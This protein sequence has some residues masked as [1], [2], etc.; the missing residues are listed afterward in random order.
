MTAYTLRTTRAYF[1]LWYGVM[2]AYRVEILL[3]AIA[4]ALPLIMMGIWVEAGASGKFAGF[5][6][7]DA[8]RYFIAVFVVRQFSVVWV[9]Y[10][11][12]HLV[13]SGKLSSLLLHPIDPL[14]RFVLMHVAE[15]AARLPFV[16]ALVAMAFWLQPQALFGSD[17]QPGVWQPVWWRLLL[18]VVLIGA[19]FMLRFLMQYAVAMLAFRLERVQ[20]IDGL[21]FMPY[22]F[23]SG[24][25]VPLQVMPEGV[26]GALL[27]TPFPYLIWFPAQ[28]ITGAPVDVGQGLGV[29]AGWLVGLFLINRWAWSRGLRHYSAMGA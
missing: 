5:T 7:V 29:L 28:V 24:M 21:F 10:E 6:S 20:A 16:F 19:A 8:A 23:F 13:N 2:M 11:F 25:V 3:W 22:L 15:W 18:G 26:A 14:P 1:S 17:A 4:T 12:E 9:I 27:W